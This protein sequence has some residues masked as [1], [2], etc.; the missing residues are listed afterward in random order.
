MLLQHVHIRSYCWCW[1]IRAISYSQHLL[2]SSYWRIK[3]GSLHCH[4]CPLPRNKRHK[5]TYGIWN[6]LEQPPTCDPSSSEDVTPFEKNETKNI[7]VNMQ[8]IRTSHTLRK[9][10]VDFRWFSHLYNT[11]PHWLSYK[12]QV[13]SDVIFQTLLMTANLVMTAWMTGHT[14]MRTMTLCFSWG[15]LYQEYSLITVR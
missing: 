15:R 14:D 4:T 9:P 8:F 3:E 2:F 12:G 10:S 11:G 6:A 7:E 13:T 1:I 5:S